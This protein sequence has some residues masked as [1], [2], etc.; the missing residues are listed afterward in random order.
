MDIKEYIVANEKI[1][2]G[3][4]AVNYIFS[5]GKNSDKL[6]VTFPG[7]AGPGMPPQY[8][9]I[10]TLMNCNCHRLYILD[11]YGPRGSYLIGENRDHSI[12]DS[13]V[14]LISSI[15][16]KFNIKSKNVILQGSSKGGFC[17]LYYGIKY[18]FGY[19]IT[20]APQTKLGDYLVSFPE[21]AEFVAGGKN[22]EDI[23]YLNNLL[24][25]LIDIPSNSFPK[26]FIHVGKGDHHYK[27]HILP[28]IEELDKKRII[29]EINLRNYSSHGIIGTY[30]PKYLLKTLN[31]I[32]NNIISLPKPAIT[33]TT[34]KPGKGLLE[35]TC[36]A[37]GDNLKYACD[38]YKEN[39]VIEKFIYQKEF[40]FKY[41]INSR[42]SYHAILYV[43]DKKYNN[44]TITDEISINY[45]DTHK[46]IEFQEK[47]KPR[48]TL[49]K[50]F[51]LSY[52]K[53]LSSFRMGI[54]NLKK[55]PYYLHVVQNDTNNYTFKIINT[56]SN[57]LFAW[58]I[59]KN[60]ERVDVIWYDANPVLTYQF[61]EPGNYQI[62]YFIQ[63]DED[64]KMYTPS[65][66][67][68]IT[69][70][71]IINSNNMTKFD[72]KK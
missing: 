38:L 16:E 36:K 65:R 72:Y 29:Y 54:N 43:K 17:A 45:T 40:N 35:I 31:N 64:K 27:E 20:G 58:Y 13:V 6:I 2:G 59:L 26:I 51:F 57:E 56:N 9:Y 41:P 71:D 47:L 70:E 10:R 52:Q 48:N 53:M 61:T 8:N 1:Y 63:K 7:F 34:I 37:T 23:L 4:K 14:S 42:G 5:K 33:K 39:T 32:D 30:Y 15:Y 19:V 28:F 55:T 24:Y 12:E 3:K 18:N 49:E 21:V 25:D 62:R 22:K 67:I 69:D 44:S 66:I 11:D 68:T 50:K 60:G 46:W